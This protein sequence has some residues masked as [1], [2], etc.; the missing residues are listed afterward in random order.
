[1]EW[2]AARGQLAKPKLILF[3]NKRV[4]AAKGAAAQV[5]AL[6]KIQR[7]NNGRLNNDL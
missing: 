4:A 3:F 2:G 5:A 6:L 1:L 7:G